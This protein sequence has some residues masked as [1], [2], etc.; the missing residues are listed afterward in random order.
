MEIN[1]SRNHLENCR[2]MT[3][4]KVKTS[5]GKHALK[6][7][8]CMMVRNEEDMVADAISCIRNQTLPPICIYVLNDGSTDSTGQILDGMKDVVVTSNPPHPPEH[9]DV[10]HIAKR[11]E[12]IYVAAMDTDYILCMDADVYIPPEYMERITERMKLDNVT[13][14]SGTD[15]TALKMWP[16]EPG[17]VIDAKWL[18]THPNLPKYAIPHLVVESALDEHLSIVYRNIHLRYKR[19]FGT[20]YGSDVLKFRGMHQR[21]CGLSFWW[22]L[23][24]FL[25]RRKWHVLWGYISYK[26]DKLP[27]RYG[28][29]INRYYMARAKMKIGMKQRL[30][31]DTEVGMFILPEKH[32][33]SPT[34]LHG[35]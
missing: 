15:P 16:I 8:A 9:S 1:D 31:L 30:L 6:W 25:R 7:S 35:V 33:I 32:I 11:H 3:N 4:E 24:L 27:K 12:L 29:Y 13:V 28:Q 10:R 17:L 18:N 19:L 22:A 23:A 20:G 14:A 21:M 5:I 34:F 2:Q 26:G